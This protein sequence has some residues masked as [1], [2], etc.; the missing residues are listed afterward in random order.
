MSNDREAAG[1]EFHEEVPVKAK[2]AYG[3]ANGANQLMSGIGLN[4]INAFYIK[5]FNLDPSLIGI[6]W[7]LFMAWNAINDPLI[8]I[9]EER[10]Q[11][12]LGRRVPYLRYGAVAYG[13]AFIL[14]WFPV[15]RWSQT[16]LFINHLLTLFVFDTL[17]SMVGL[18]TYSLPAEMA[19]TSEARSNI[20]IWSTFVSSFG[21]IGSMVI[22]TSLLTGDNPDL[23]VFQSV[24]T[25]VGIIAAILMYGSSYFIKENRW[26][27]SEPTLGFWES[28]KETFKNKQFLILEGAI[29]MLV[30]MQNTIVGGVTFLFDYLLVFEGDIWS[31]VLLVLLVA[32]FGY[33]I[34]F[35]NRGISKYGL[36]KLTIYSC[37]LGST[38]MGVLLVT[39]LLTGSKLTLKT[40]FVGLMFIIIGLIGYMLINQPLMGDAIDYDELRTGKRR[41]TT[42]SGVNALITKPAVS[43]GQAAFLWILVYYGYDEEK[44]VSEQPATV[45]TGVLVAFTLIPM[46]CMLIA[47][48]FMHFY[49]L[50]GPE[51]QKTKKELQMKH[52]RK[53]EEHI[54]KLAEEGVLKELE[55]EES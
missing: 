17:Y 3:V 4:S 30:L 35:I 11:S 25:L 28:I 40:G 54:R 32:W 51:W 44:K 18:V 29:F 46:V 50:E 5:I 39:G 38:G 2:V 53:E 27:Q 22:P 33:T 24:M 26:A 52:Q 20:I 16:A 6:S 42:Y 41:E 36:K 12:K 37:I 7:I 43:I 49:R 14:I 47:M 9:L 1:V 45:S 19:V 15:F 8:G 55:T 21:V 23:G 34:Y 10:T 48:V 13:L 31:Y